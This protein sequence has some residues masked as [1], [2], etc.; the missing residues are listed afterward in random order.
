MLLETL[1]AGSLSLTPVHADRIDLRSILQYRQEE[2]AQMITLPN[3]D[4]EPYFTCD[5][6]KRNFTLATLHGRYRKDR[7]IFDLG[8]YRVAIRQ[9]GISVS[10][11]F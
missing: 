9:Y 11:D 4:L 8:K 10:F 5:V 3:I 6:T 7:V 2:K 1:L